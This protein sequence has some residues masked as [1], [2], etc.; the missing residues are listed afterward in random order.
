MVPR[1]REFFRQGQAEVVSNSKNKILATWELFFRRALYSTSCVP[2]SLSTGYIVIGYYEGNLYNKLNH[3]G[4]LLNTWQLKTYIWS[5]F[6]P[7]LGTAYCCS[8]LPPQI[9]DR[10]IPSLQTM[11]FYRTWFSSFFQSHRKGC[12]GSTPATPP[13]RKV[14]SNKESGLSKF[15]CEHSSVD[16]TRTWFNPTC[17]CLCLVVWLLALTAHLLLL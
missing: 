1:L 12:I 13:I 10:H 7:Y 11:L 17:L 2:S 4:V 3:L 8:L 14:L 9:V 5:D 15:F 6:I 16:L